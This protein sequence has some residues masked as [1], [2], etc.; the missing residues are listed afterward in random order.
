MPSFPCLADHERDWPPCKVVF[1]G[2]ATN[3]LNVRNN[4]NNN[5]NNSICQLSFITFACVCF[6]PIYSGRQFRW[7]YQ[8]GS[9]RRKVTQDF[10]S[11]FLLRCMPLFFLREEFIRSF[12]SL[13]VKSNFVYYRFNRS[14]LVG[15]LFFLFFLFLS[16]KKYQLPGFELMSQHVRNLRGY[17]L[18]Y[19]GNLPFIK[20]KHFCFLRSTVM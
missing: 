3:T 8:L 12:P 4:N 11:T 10:S 6:L 19:R 15:H 2:L 20:N 18:S 7:M 5:N 9:H 16:E 14:P 13:T 17:Q 1:F